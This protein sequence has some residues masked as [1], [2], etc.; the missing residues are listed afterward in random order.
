MDY[1]SSPYQEP[2]TPQGALPN[3]TAVLVLGIISIVGC[4]CYGL[5]GIICGT[6]ALVL[7]NKDRRLYAASPA[8]YTPGSY[9]NL[10]AGRTC[11]I[12]GLC[13]SSLYLIGIIFAI[14]MWGVAALND[15]THFWQNM[16]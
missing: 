5:P 12:I 11:A 13:L 6:I 4:I 7:A 8:S 14:F 2:S 15:P 16:R 1:Q 10:K 3:A 9:S